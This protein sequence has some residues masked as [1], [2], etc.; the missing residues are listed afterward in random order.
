MSADSW[1]APCSAALLFIFGCT[2]ISSAAPT[3]SENAGPARITVMY[4]AFGK[5]AG[6][7]RDWGY[8]ALVEYGGKRILFDTGNNPDI[9]AQ[10]TKAKNIDLSTVDFVV[11]SHRHG[12]HM[13]GLTYVLKVNPHVKI[14]APKEGFG[15]YGADLPSTFYRKDGSL[16]V[17]QRYYDGTPPEI[18]RLDQPGPPLTSSSSTGIL[19]LLPTSP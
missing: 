9:L 12:D 4:D 2:A 14:Y 17:E 6:M 18:M 13:G 10:N 8:A 11:M 7:Q 3:A 15:V 5:S 1:T 16:P 19:R